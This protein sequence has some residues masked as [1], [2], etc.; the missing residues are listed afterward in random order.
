[1][2]RRLAG[3]LPVRIAITVAILALLARTIDFAEAWR[4][5]IRVDLRAVL[6]VAGLVALD[7]VVMIWRWLLLLRSTGSQVT[8]GEA[9]RIFLVSSFVGSFL[10][11]GVGGDA[12]RAWQLARHTA[13]GSEAIASVAVDRLLGVVSIVCLGAL[14]ALAAS[15]LIPATQRGP[16]LIGAGMLAVAGVALLWVDRALTL[17]PRSVR[18]GAAGVRLIALADAMAAYRRRP[19]VLVAVLALSF[20]VQ[21]LRIV[22]AACLG[23]GLGLA[24]PF[25]YFL[26]FMPIG[27]MMLLLPIS[28][29]GFGL[30]QGVIVWLLRP[31]SV[32]DEASFALA[33]LIVLSGLAGNLPGG[34]LFL[35]QRGRR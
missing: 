7:R 20:G 26:A 22:Q 29:S 15:N 35:R 27:L 34:W 1:M 19:A 30:P 31:M 25:R 17:L 33:T 14:G 4:A 16:L 23:W 3:S 8:T 12:A 2:I 5:I 24:V 28:V 9:A 21:L 11:A 6:L 32:P 10:P 18:E 13:R